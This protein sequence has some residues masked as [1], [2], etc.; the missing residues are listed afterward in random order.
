MKEKCKVKLVPTSMRL[1][2]LLSRQI[3]QGSK[4]CKN[5]HYKI[6]INTG[7]YFWENI[8]KCQKCNLDEFQ[9]QNSEKRFGER[10][11][12]FNSKSSSYNELSSFNRTNEFNNDL[13]HLL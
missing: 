7:K 12:S 10:D 1:R 5:L 11:S 9:K 2:K 13:A 4:D 3:Y 6:D 8:N